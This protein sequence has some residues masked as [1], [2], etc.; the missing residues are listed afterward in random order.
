[1]SNIIGMPGAHEPPAAKPA[2]VVPVQGWDNEYTG[3]VPAV[4]LNPHAGPLARVAWALGQLTQVNNW[5]RVMN[6]ESISDGSNPNE[7]AGAILHFTEQ[8]ESVLKT[9]PRMVTAEQGGSES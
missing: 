9:V 2:P 7:L 6:V 3:D 5:L 1:M 4:V 8:A